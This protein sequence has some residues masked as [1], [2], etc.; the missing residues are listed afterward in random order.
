MPAP[1]WLRQLERV[2]GAPMLWLGIG[3]RLAGLEALLAGDWM[4]ADAWQ[5]PERRGHVVGH[6]IEIDGERIPLWSGRA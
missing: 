1:E 5:V 6:V 4:P 2:P 3:P